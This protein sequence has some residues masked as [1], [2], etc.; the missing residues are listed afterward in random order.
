[1]SA[2]NM[3]G[4]GPHGYDWAVGTWSCTNSMP[5]AMGGPSSMTLKVAR[6]NG[7][8]IFFRS[9]GTN[10]DNSWYNIYVPSKKMWLSPFIVSDGSYGTESTTQTGPKVVWTGSAFDATS[11][12]TVQVRDTTVFAPTKYTDLGEQ[13]SGGLWKTQYNVSCTR[14]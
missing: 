6:T 12:K 7:G 10:F 3:Y 13:K 5:S 4:V 8:S 1:M 9:T 14:A 11:G 2:T